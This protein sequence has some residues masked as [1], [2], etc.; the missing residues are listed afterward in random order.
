M[1]SFSYF[2]Q[3][4]KNNYRQAKRSQLQIHIC[5]LILG[6]FS[7]NHLYQIMTTATESL[8]YQHSAWNETL[9]NTHTITHGQRDLFLAPGAAAT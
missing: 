4:A 1:L 5:L 3:I 7:N 9:L 2:L 6:A 8:T